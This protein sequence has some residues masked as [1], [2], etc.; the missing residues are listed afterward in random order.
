MPGD[1]ERPEPFSGKG[2]PTFTVRELLPWFLV[3]LALFM[4]AV[5]LIAAA[6]QQQGGGSYGG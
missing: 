1:R 6:A 4:V 3:S 5:R 2:V